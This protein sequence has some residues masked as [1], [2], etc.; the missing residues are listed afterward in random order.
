MVSRPGG[1]CAVVPVVGIVEEGLET[2]VDWSVVAVTVGT[3]P[4]ETAA[5]LTE[6]GVVRGRVESGVE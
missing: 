1:V 4:V 6:P 5:V 2:G 3:T